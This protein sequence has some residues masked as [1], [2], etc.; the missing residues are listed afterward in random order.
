[1]AALL[2]ASFACSGCT[3]F[4]VGDASGFGAGEAGAGSG[5]C[6][7][8]GRRGAGGCLMRER[9]YDLGN[10]YRVLPTVL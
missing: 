7:V 2:P 3:N 9:V 5:L 8:W 6:A 1:M 4:T 10:D